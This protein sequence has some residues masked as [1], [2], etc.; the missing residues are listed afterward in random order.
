[1]H[2]ALVCLPILVFESAV[3]VGEVEVASLIFIVIVI[4]VVMT[5]HYPSLSVNTTWVENLSSVISSVCFACSRCAPY[6]DNEM[7]GMD[8]MRLGDGDDD[9]QDEDFE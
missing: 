1:M 5:C 2:S 7:S 8:G 3:V 4:A 9:E 6:I